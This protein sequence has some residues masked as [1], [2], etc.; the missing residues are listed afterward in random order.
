MTGIIAIP[1]SPSNP[2]AATLPSAARF[3][4]YS[5]GNY[6]LYSDDLDLFTVTVSSLH[7]QTEAISITS[8]NPCNPIFYTATHDWLF[9]SH[10]IQKLLSHKHT[11]PL[12]DFHSISL[13]VC[14]GCIP[15][16]SSL[17]SDIYTVPS[18]SQLIYHSE[19]F[20]VHCTSFNTSNFLSYL[21]PLY[22]LGI[23][24]S[25]SLGEYSNYAQY[26]ERFTVMQNQLI[27]PFPFDQSS[28]Y[29]TTITEYVHLQSVKSCIIKIVNA[30]HMGPLLRFFNHIDLDLFLAS[31]FL[32][33]PYK[34][35]IHF[36]LTMVS[37]APCF[38]SKRFV[39]HIVS[40]QYPYA[41]LSLPDSH[42]PL[43]HSFLQSVY[44]DM[45]TLS[46]LLDSH[47]VKPSIFKSR[48][49]FFISWHLSNIS[50]S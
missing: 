47:N 49:I 25:A 13:F 21:D 17:L 26:L 36:L 48:L 37:G 2:Y 39:G 35:V 31:Y 3:N 29:N 20:F 27:L 46:D 12:V 8:S 7:S 33:V 34:N 18:N 23:T 40:Y 14:F 6:I 19:F 5:L 9:V 1:L 43:T 16:G 42:S 50:F 11:C 15:Y 4:H 44:L 38:E 45:A 41:F 32:G 30:S 22:P 28:S 24:S 10:S